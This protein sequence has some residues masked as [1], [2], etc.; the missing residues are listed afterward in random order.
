MGTVL[1]VKGNFSSRSMGV[2]PYV[3]DSYLTAPSNLSFIQ[4]YKDEYKISFLASSLSSTGLSDGIA[5]DIIVGDVVVAS[6]TN[7]FVVLSG[8]VGGSYSVK[9]VA[10]MGGL[11][12]AESNPIV[13]NM[14]AAHSPAVSA[15][16]LSITRNASLPGSN[17]NRYYYTLS[18]ATALRSKQLCAI[19]FYSVG[20]HTVNIYK[21]FNLLV[22]GTSVK[23]FTLV[24]TFTSV[25]GRNYRIIPTSILG[26]NEFLCFTIPGLSFISASNYGNHF[27]GYAIATSIATDYSVNDICV[28]VYALD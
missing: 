21:A 6:T 9:V 28:T 16:S 12:S 7:T 18:A 23:T 1:K 13:V 19:E 4:T 3:G 14:L 26:D 25:I 27:S 11:V 20:L 5:Y 24:D 8:V 17:T 10:K 15:P 2:Y 22:S